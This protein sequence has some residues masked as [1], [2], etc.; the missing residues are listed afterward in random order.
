VYSILA[1]G[2]EIKQSGFNHTPLL[3]SDSINTIFVGTTASDSK[4]QDL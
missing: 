3:M 4:Y 2:V 1:V